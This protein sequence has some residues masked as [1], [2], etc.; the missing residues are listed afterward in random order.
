[1]CSVAMDVH[2]HLCAHFREEM[3]K[4]SAPKNKRLSICIGIQFSAQLLSGDP[5]PLG[6]G[7][8]KLMQCLI[9]R[10]GVASLTNQAVPQVVQGA[11]DTLAF[12][13]CKIISRL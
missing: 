6:L 8:H 12:L 13:V 1:M 3:Q 10:V 4:P 2:E 5:Y 7:S 11:Y 9:Y